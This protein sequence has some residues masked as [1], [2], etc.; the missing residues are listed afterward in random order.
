MNNLTFDAEKHYLGKLCCRGHEWELTGK[1]IR[2]QK[3]YGCVVCEQERNRKRNHISWIKK[4]QQEGIDCSEIGAYY[5]GALCRRGHDWEGSGKSLRYQCD[6]KCVRCRLGD[7]WI[8]C[9][10]RPKQTEEE[11]LAKRRQYRAAHSAQAVERSKKWRK[12]NPERFAELVRQFRERNRDRINKLKRDSYPEDR[13]RLRANRKRY[14][15]SEKGKATK[16][17]YRINHKDRLN[18]LAR[19]RAKLPEN[20]VKKL[21]SFHRR[22]ATK[23]SNHRVSYTFEQVKQLEKKF[24]DQCAY[25]EKSGKLTLDHFV[26]VSKGGPDCLGNLVP[27][28]LSCNSAKGNRDTQVWYENQSFYSKSR[29]RKI[30][31]V[32]GK[33]EANLAQLPLF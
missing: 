3:S 26:P 8:P 19:I 15:S 14:L 27:A 13:D 2:Y 25:C 4:V 5:L 33:S 12:E 9:S 10:Q 23:R 24:N 21:V 18:E 28:C 17:S 31:K 32:L 7:D 1:S 30:L 6:T 20:R 29:W 11:T 16:R 22:Q